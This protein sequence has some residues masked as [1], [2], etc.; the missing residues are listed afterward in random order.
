M[1]AHRERILL[2]LQPDTGA[3]NIMVRTELR[4]EQLSSLSWLVFAAVDTLVKDWYN[5]NVT[6]LVPCTHCLS[7]DSP[8]PF[9]FPLEKCQQAAAS[10]NNSF[11]HCPNGTSD[12]RFPI[13]HSRLLP[14]S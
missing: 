10:P 8:T 4:G 1:R 7:L 2:E 3:L 13:Q 5:L 12:S 11:L 6:T 9:M 14:I